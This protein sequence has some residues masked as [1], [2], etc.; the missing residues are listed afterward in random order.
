L[1]AT[2]EGVDDLLARATTGRWSPLQLIE[3][4][5]RLEASA[6]ATRNLQRRLKLVALGRFKPLADFDWNWPSRLT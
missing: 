1:R 2:S 6:K 4:I 5:A 3:E